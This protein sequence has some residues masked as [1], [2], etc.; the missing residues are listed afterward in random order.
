MTENQKG[1]IIPIAGIAVALI[2]IGILGY[3]SYRDYFKGGAAE[4]Q[5]KMV[6]KPSGD[7]VLK[8]ASPSATPFASGLVFN[9]PQ[10]LA[11]DEEETSPDGKYTF[12]LDIAEYP[13]E[14][15]SYKL[16]ETASGKIIKLSSLSDRIPC[17]QGMGNTSAFL[18][19]GD[20][21]K[22]A[23]G[24]ASGKIAIIDIPSDTYT[25]HTYKPELMFRAVSKDFSKWLFS[26]DTGDST[27]FSVRDMSNAEL[28]EISVSSDEENAYALFRV[29]SDMKNNGFVFISRNYKPPKNG[30]GDSRVSYKF[31]FLP[32][33]DLNFKTVLVTD[34]KSVPGRGCGNDRLASVQGEI[35]IKPSCIMVNDKYMSSDNAIHIKL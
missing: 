2:I 29:L 17:E 22:L 19:L 20:N 26:K 32:A 5:K 25:Y 24:L 15:C 33:D 18:G 21:G 8:E 31:D 9:N 4:T 10:L 27:V 1:G 12:S 11:Y 16:T 13:S 6:Q 28:L 7:T 14:L 35:I 3:S 30:S 23:V 34:Y